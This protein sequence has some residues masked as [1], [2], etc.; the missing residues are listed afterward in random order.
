MAWPTAACLVNIID[1]RQLEALK[2]K[3]GFGLKEA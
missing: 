3:F 2:A 1:E